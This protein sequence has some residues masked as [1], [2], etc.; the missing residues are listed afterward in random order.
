MQS[1]MKKS[2]D[3]TN[4]WSDHSTPRKARRLLESALLRSGV[5]SLSKKVKTD[6]HTTVHLTSSGSMTKS[7]VTSSSTFPLTPTV[8]A[9]W[10]SQI[11]TDYG[12]GVSDVWAGLG[13]TVR[14]SGLSVRL[15]AGGA[16]KAV[17]GTS[18][19]FD[20]RTG[21]TAQV[22]VGGGR[23]SVN[24]RTWRKIDGRNRATVAVGR[25][26]GSNVLRAGWDTFWE[27]GSASVEAGLGFLRVRAG[28]DIAD[29]GRAKGSVRFGS[30]VELQGSLKRRVSDV[31]V[32]EVAV[33]ADFTR[34]VFLVFKV[35][36]NGS[37]LEVPVAL[38]DAVSLFWVR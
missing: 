6:S 30:G 5:N 14:G 13:T 12:L 21:A 26:G 4:P 37:V 20:R 38:T 17:V 35:D 32:L 24:V 15:H 31:M 3:L 8:Q 16:G 19:Q 29:D 25:G 2:T 34:G 7:S 1:E 23:T 22:E 36:R 18:R 10:G 33:K 27:G 9:M 28:Q 11:V